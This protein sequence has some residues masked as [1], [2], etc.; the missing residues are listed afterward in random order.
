MP[1]DQFYKW[2]KELEERS[3]K[4][5]IELNE[6]NK[7]RRMLVEYSKNELIDFIMRERNQIKHLNNIIDGL[8]KK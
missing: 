7:I 1:N 3:K 4:C 8:E 6:E 5:M 2:T